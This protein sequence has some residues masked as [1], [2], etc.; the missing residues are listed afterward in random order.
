MAY[1]PWQ[2]A[3]N[4]FIDH[5][6]NGSKFSDTLLVLFLYYI[7]RDAGLYLYFMTKATVW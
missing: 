1:T 5:L 7:K 2:N 6:T 3:M 4:A